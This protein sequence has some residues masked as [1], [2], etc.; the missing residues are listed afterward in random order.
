MRSGR[1][2][3]ALSGAWSGR[4]LGAVCIILAS[5]LSEACA[6]DQE[7]RD[8]GIYV[9]G[10]PAGSAQ[11]AMVRQDDG[12][13]QLTCSTH[14]KVR[15]LLITYTYQYQGKEV[16]KDGRLQR[17]DSS[18]NDDGKRFQVSAVAAEDGLHVTT[19]GRE[20]VAP[21]EAWLTSNWSLPSPK[22]RDQVVPLIDADTGEDL[23]CRIQHIGTV[24]MSVAGQVQNV[25][26]YRL[27]GAKMQ[28]E[29]WYDGAERLVRRE[30]VEQGHRTVLELARIHR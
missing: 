25:N 9:D 2:G 12:T 11:M 27:N 26:H 8:F 13:T 21:A 6:A 1:W 10:K 7:T 23:S 14:V 28:V 20:H 3:V 15:V 19:N 24:Q 30:W 16:W 17:L 4:L 5:G 22:Q 18:C 29:V